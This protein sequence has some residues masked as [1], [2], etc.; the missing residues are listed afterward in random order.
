[1]PL[2]N[3]KRI[4]LIKLE[5]TYGTDAVPVTTDAVL[6][7]A[8]NINPLEGSA[9]QRDLVRPYFSNDG[10]IRVENFVTLDF[11]TEIAGSGT[12]GTVPKW[13][14]LLKACNF[15]ETITAAAIT[16][17]TSTAIGAL[18]T[19][20]V[21]LS[22][23]ASAIDDF[24]TGM[25]IAFD[26]LSQQ[27][28]IVK[29]VG[30][31]KTAT[32][33]KGLLT[34]ITAT[35]T[36]NIGANVI[37]TP[38]SNFS[39]NVASTS[40]SIY[41][42]VDGVRHVLLGA[43]GT[44]SFDLS[45]KLVPKMKWKF[46][47]LLGT[48]SDVAQGSPAADTSLWQTPVTVSTA[49]TTDINLLG[50][51]QSVLEKLTIDVVNTVAYRQTLGSESVLITDRKPVGA[52]ALEA[53]FITTTQG[54][55]LPKDWWTAVKTSAVGTFCVKHG[56]V[57]GNI[58]AFSGPKVQFEAPKY[59]DSNGVL[60]LDMNIAFIPYGISGNDELRICCK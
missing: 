50:Y 55:I 39:I 1:M 10:S 29:Y 5:P 49:N 56:Q 57:A 21:T 6:C 38:N 2:S 44:V 4:I 58:V 43:R 12:A 33:S 60:M 14:T 22:A 48:I 19:T 13:A 46:T 40:A 9:V 30:A 18:G 59:S 27:Y 24:Y 52:V 53:G 31:T 51:T 25:S 16:T 37:Y 8:L 42:N 32:L 23:A 3:K 11:E 45:P 7:T 54:T 41:F 15:T 17:L 28:E 36:T 34:A 35:S 20:A 26:G 47:G